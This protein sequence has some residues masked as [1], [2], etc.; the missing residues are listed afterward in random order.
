M[1]ARIVRFGLEKLGY[2][3]WKREFL[4]YGVLPFLDISRLSKAWGRPVSIIFD[5]GANTGQTSQEMRSAFPDAQIHAFEPHPETF[6]RLQTS[7]TKNQFSAYQLA[8]G[9]REGDATLYEYAA[10]GDGSLINSLTPNA[11]FA[12]QHGYSAAALR[13]VGCTTIDG[14]CAKHN[15]DHINVLKVDTEGYD[16]HVLR[17]AEV[18]LAQERVGFVYVEFNDVEPKEGAT[19]GALAPIASFLGSFKLRHVASYTDFV[20]PEQG[21]FVCANALFALPP[22]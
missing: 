5:V 13:S 6:R 8:L 1:P 20:L 12:I 21:L 19:G 7:A 11:R 9:D 16:L 18:M 2:V 10:S 22:H 15:I 4:R 14:F 3:L 17:G